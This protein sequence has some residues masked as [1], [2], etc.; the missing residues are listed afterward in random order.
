MSRGGWIF[1]LLLPVV[2]GPLVLAIPYVRAGCPPLRYRREGEAPG[3]DGWNVRG[4]SDG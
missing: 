2:L 4:G 3:K 1:L